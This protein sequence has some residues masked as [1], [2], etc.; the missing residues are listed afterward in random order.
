MP[1]ERHRD[2]NGE[3]SRKHGNTLIRTLRSI[4]AKIS[5]SDART[6]RNLATCGGPMD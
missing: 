5:P 4:T 6:M 3:M 2:K 1:L